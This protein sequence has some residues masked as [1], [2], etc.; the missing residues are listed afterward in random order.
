MQSYHHTYADTTAM[1]IVDVTTQDV[2]IFQAKT[3]MFSHK[4][5]HIS[6]KFQE[7]Q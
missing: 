3:S 2:L 6:G 1:C 7:I 4:H 5:V